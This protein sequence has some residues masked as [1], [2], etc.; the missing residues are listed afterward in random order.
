ML[1]KIYDRIPNSTNNLIKTV[2]ITVFHRIDWS[3]NNVSTG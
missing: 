2:N 1:K 3:F